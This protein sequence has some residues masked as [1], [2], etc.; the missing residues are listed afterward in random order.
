MLQ[1]CLKFRK[2]LV[3]KLKTPAFH[4]RCHIEIMWLNS[5]RWLVILICTKKKGLTAEMASS[6]QG[7]YENFCIPLPCSSICHLFYIVMNWRCSSTSVFVQCVW[8]T[9]YIHVRNRTSYTILGTN[10]GHGHATVSRAKKT[11]GG[12]IW[13]QMGSQPLKLQSLWRRHLA[14][15]YISCWIDVN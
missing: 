3:P 4:G 14:E 9:R 2:I 5:R 11:G 12:E 15:G 6:G 1:V 13:S 7:Q 10:Q 8:N